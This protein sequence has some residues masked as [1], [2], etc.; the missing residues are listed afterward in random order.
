MRFTLLTASL[1]TL[2]ATTAARADPRPNADHFE[3]TMGFLVTA[4]D[5]SATAFAPA[6]G[7]PSLAAAFR[8]APFDRV[9]G[10]GLRYDARGVISHV[11]MTVGF[12][13]PFTAWGTIPSAR[14]DE[15]DVTPRDLSAWAVRFGLGGE[16]S[17]GAITPYA[18]LFGALQHVSA[19]MTVDGQSRRYDASRFGFSARVGVRAQLRSWFFVAASGEVGLGAPTLWSA[20]LQAGFSVGN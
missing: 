12:D 6:N 11:R 17:F 18:D 9:Q 19:E 4:S 10:Y 14:V 15:H 16:Y 1:A 20:D 7:G 8:T 3:A 13:L 2:L 5:H